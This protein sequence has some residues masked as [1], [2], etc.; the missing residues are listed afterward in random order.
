[1]KKHPVDELFAKKLSTW[2]PKASSDVWKRIEA[3]QKEKA[4]KVVPVGWYWY[5]AASVV[6]VMLASYLV[7][8][9]QASESGQDTRTIAQTNQKATEKAK[10]SQP[11][12]VLPESERLAAINEPIRAKETI[13]ISSADTATAIKAKTKTRSHPLEEELAPASDDV[14]IAKVERE[15]TGTNALPLANKQ[16]AVQPSVQVP[17]VQAEE[18]TEEAAASRVIIAHIETD[19]LSEENPKSSKFI[20]IL[21]QL[22]NAKQ[23]EAVDWDEV[24]INP[25]RILARADER[26]RNEE[27]KLSKQYQ[28]LKEKTKL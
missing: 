14:A 5:A 23:G 7:W 12:E 3:K 25:K 20:R 28:N 22:K 21:K 10:K 9:G 24:G 26:L 16:I 13:Q 4:T 11:E 27:D 18:K 1:M 6:V 17:A 2:E 15:A 19:D 8:Q